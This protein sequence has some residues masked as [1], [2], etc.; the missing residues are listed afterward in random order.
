MTRAQLSALGCAL[1]GV[2]Y[3][4]DLARALNLNARLVRH[5]TSGTRQVPQEVRHALRA[6]ATDKARQLQT[7]ARAL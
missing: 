6:L 7:M 4:S 3:Q 1:Y 2:H 5:W